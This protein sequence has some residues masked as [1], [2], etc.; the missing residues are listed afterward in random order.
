MNC[1][2]FLFSATLQ[3]SLLSVSLLVLQSASLQYRYL[4]I[5]YFAL[6]WAPSP[7]LFYEPNPPSLQAPAPIHQHSLCPTF[8]HPCCSPVWEGRLYWELPRTENSRSLQSTP[9]NSAVLLSEIC[10]LYKALAVK[11]PGAAQLMHYCNSG[12]LCILYCWLQVVKSCCLQTAN[13]H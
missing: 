5:L 13:C 4:R 1:L 7:F 8:F 9:P 3:P 12:P 2:N 6:C 11:L 10:K